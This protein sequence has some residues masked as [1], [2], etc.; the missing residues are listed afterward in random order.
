MLHAAIMAQSIQE[1]TKKT[2]GRQPLKNLKGYG[3]PQILLG[4]NLNT[5]S[6]IYSFKTCP[7][8]KDTNIYQRP[9]SS[10]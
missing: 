6:H 5:L 1:W 9:L 8:H 4:S 2:C 10:S 7:S 3:L